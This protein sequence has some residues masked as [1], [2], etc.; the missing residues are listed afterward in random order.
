MIK[1]SLPFILWALLLVSTA[2]AE[3]M[4]AQIVRGLSPENDRNYLEYFRNFALN[5][6]EHCK[7][8][9]S[10]AFEKNRALAEACTLSQL[11]QVYFMRLGTVQDSQHSGLNLSEFLE[12]SPEMWIPALT[13]GAWEVVPF[14]D[15]DG[16]VTATEILAS[17]IGIEKA[18][19]F[20]AKHIQSLN[21]STFNTFA[22]YSIPRMI[23]AFSGHSFA[24]RVLAYAHAFDC[25][26]PEVAKTDACK[27]SRDFITAI[28]QEVLAA[29]GSEDFVSQLEKLNTKNSSRASLKVHQV[30]NAV[31]A[32]QK[33]R[34]EALPT[35]ILLSIN[36]PQKHPAYKS[37]QEAIIVISESPLPKEEIHRMLLAVS[38]LAEIHSLQQKVSTLPPSSELKSPL[39]IGPA[40]SE[41][42]YEL[43]SWVTKALIEEEQV[44]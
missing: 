23:G 39:G 14:V 22:S 13:A 1:T 2:S 32:I 43:K 4:T 17:R 40:V 41:Q 15:A 21:K 28:Q 38:I 12:M 34:D 42:I 16:V 26:L 19:L 9:S 3:P 29:L 8:W 27:E 31:V 30:L 37:L 6:N 10:Q 5:S 20:Q 36:S 35:E 11:S 33:L 18:L 24:V 44:L 7:T 25:G